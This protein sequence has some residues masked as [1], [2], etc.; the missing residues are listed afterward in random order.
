MNGAEDSQPQVPSISCCAMRSLCL[1]LLAAMPTAVLSAP[2]KVERNSKALEFSYEWPAEAAAIAALNTRFKAE[3][4]KAFQEQLEN[5]R[6]D[7]KL[8]REQ[9]RDVSPHFYAMKWTTAGQ[10]PR[11]LSLQF[12]LGSYTGGA[13]PNTTYGALLWD[14]RFAR[15]IKVDDQF[16]HAGTFAAL[17]R[18]SYCKKLDAERLKKR[19]GEKLGGE[20]DKCPPYSD[21]AIEPADTDK[22]GR[23][24]TIRFVAAPYAAGP[25]VEGEYDVSLPVTRQLIA[26]I[27]PLYRNS[28]EAQRQ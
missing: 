16:L 14:R 12:Q 1:F 22:D 7:E 18:S 26:A 24:D 11:L 13:H 19:E 6:E 23:F 9:K 5:A 2:V 4:K 28:Y 27:K 25:Y 3:V 20:F 15:Q 17:T 10:T 21:L 8:A